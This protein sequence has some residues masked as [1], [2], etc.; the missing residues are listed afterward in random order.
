MILREQLTLP[1]HN[2]KE[3]QNNKEEVIQQVPKKKG[4]EPKLLLNKKGK[5][6]K[7]KAIQII[8]SLIRKLYNYIIYICSLAN[9]IT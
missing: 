7:D 3:E 2:N 9:Y 4:K 8:I 1:H 6:E 5:K